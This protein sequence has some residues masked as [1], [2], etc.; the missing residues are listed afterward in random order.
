[1]FRT[2]LLLMLAVPVLARAEDEKAR[3][4]REELERELNQMVGKQPTKVR[5]DFVPVEDPNYKLEEASF[6]LDGKPLQAPAL[7][8]LS[9]EPHLVWNGDVAPGKH[10]VH[11]KVVYA[12]TSSVIV[13]E[14]GGHKWK[15]SG[16]VSF[17]V[18]AG[19]EV[20]VKVVPTR[21]PSQKEIAKRF[22]LAL[23]A[24]P[25]MLAAL[26]DGKMPEP[27]KKPSP[28][29]AEVDAGRVV[30]AAAEKPQPKPI[31]DGPKTSASAKPAEPKPAP[32]PAAPPLPSE[33]APAPVAEAAPPVSPPA[34]PPTVAAPAP[35]PEAE[36][37]GLPWGWIGGAGAV[38]A[39]ALVVF[40]SRRRKPPRIDD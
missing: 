12:N 28:P 15:V 7:S 13:S 21:D 33:P 10:A 17:A 36:P 3:R 32:E 39:L 22:K 40:A 5:V 19:I 26:D 8:V 38:I 29:V 31:A 11:A 35:K 34:E 2:A 37:E 18:N 16:D 6:E 30:V 4:A 23:P 14:E 24:K 1:M 25:V 9:D 27:I 20:Q